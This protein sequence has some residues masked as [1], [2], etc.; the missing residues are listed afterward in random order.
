[1]IDEAIR[2]YP[3]FPKFYM[4]AGQICAG[5]GG[6]GIS[7]FNRARE[8]YQ[9]GLQQCPECAILWCLAIRL[10]EQLRGVPKARSMAEM[11]R[12]RL[13]SEE[14]VWLESIRL[15][16]RS[17]YGKLAESIAIKALQQCP[18]SGLI[19]AEEVLAAPKTAQKQK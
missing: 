7:D 17:G 16:R 15:E 11:A 1:M 3:S 12:L 5:Q 19:W 18:N 13:P 14:L 2:L 9:R 4:M 6:P 8:Y 10:E